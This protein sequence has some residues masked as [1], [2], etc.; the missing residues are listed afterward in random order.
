MTTN[1]KPGHRVI[2]DPTNSDRIY[3]TT[4]G[5][6]VWDG[7]ANGDLQ[8]SEDIETPLPPRMKTL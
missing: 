3:I 7:P 6:S 2:I 1:F 4:F 8:A 5:N